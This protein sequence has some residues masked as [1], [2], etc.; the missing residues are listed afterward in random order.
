MANVLNRSTKRYMKSVNTPDFPEED[1][2]INPDL[3][4]V[5]STPQKYWKIVGDAVLEMTT[6]EK[7]VVDAATAS[8]TP[9]LEENYQVDT[10]NAKNYLATS[11]WYKTKVNDGEYADTCRDI[12]YTYSDNSLVME[13]ERKY[14]M[15][16]SV[17]S[18]STK[19]YFSDTAAKK[20]IVEKG[21]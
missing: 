4:A 1:W 5:S 14:A 6:E 7:A 19:N 13:T 10:Y 20:I 12:T 3:S 21:V 18:T 15:D 8:I 11:T 16:G 2:I 17:M 9:A